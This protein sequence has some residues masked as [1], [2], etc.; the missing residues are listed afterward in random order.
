VRVPVPDDIT[1]MQPERSLLYSSRTYWYPQG[2][3]SD[4][5]TATM[6]ITIPAAYECVASGTLVPGAPELIPGKDPESSSKLYVFDTPQP[7]RYLAFIVS[8]FVRAETVTVAFDHSSPRDG[9]G[10]PPFEGQTNATVSLSVEANPRQT[11]RGHELADRA[12][13]ILQYYES[14]I[15][16]S[17][18][19]SF[20]I[21]L[22]ESDL[23]G[24]HSPGYFAALN[25]PL[26][27]T[28]YV[29]R[30]DPASF[31]NFPEFFAAHEIAHQWW[32]QAVGWQNY[33]EQWLS[34][35]FAQYFA[36]LY[37]Q[38]AHGDDT[39]TGILRQMRK[40]A[41][42]ESPQGPV[43]L[44]Y[45][46]GHIRGE[47]RVFRA[48]VYNKGALVL[49]MLRRL[50]GDDAFF[51]GIRRYYRL[52]RFHKVGT[53]DLRA[54]MEQ[55]CGRPLDRFFEGWIYGSTLPR[56]KFNYRVEGGDV[57][58][59][60]EQVGELFDIP[61]T[62][63]LQFEDRKPVTVVVPLT[64]RTIDLRVPLAGALRGA[65]VNRDDGLLAEIVKS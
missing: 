21:A 15:G 43:Y 3:A 26:P 55:E 34:E 47:S 62:V 8:R 31:T 18:Y 56:V 36:A 60:A 29:W 24:G 41:I 13:A 46:L 33:H 53:D 50:M 9:D 37:A 58:L 27:T 40:W 64:D 2:N 23:P 51:R 61:L 49:H 38:H 16:D 17:P 63:T 39:F 59:H 7:V 35:G 44:G 19:P 4:Y 45:R 42:D 1:V 48:L 57:V 32:G 5:A 11:Q 30:N 14:L 10:L 20:T 28:P 6:R 25:Q 12:V 52:S 54:A 65:E 22:V